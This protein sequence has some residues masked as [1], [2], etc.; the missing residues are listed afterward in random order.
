AR[1]Q[2]QMCIRDRSTAPI[3][4]NGNGFMKYA[5]LSNLDIEGGEL[6]G[7]SVEWAKPTAPFQ[8]AGKTTTVANALAGKFYPWTYSYTIRAKPGVDTITIKPTAMSNRITMMLFNG[9]RVENRASLTIPATD[10]Y[11]CTLKIIAPDTLTTATYTLT[12]RQK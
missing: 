3:N 11:T 5:V 7:V 12:V 2:R 10:G 6:E 4:Y 9:I 8:W 1:R